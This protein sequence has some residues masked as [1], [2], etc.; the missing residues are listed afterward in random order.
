MSPNWASGEILRLLDEARA[1]RQLLVARFVLNHCPA[2]ATI[3]RDTADALADHEPPMLA[4]R[5]GQRV[6]FADAAQY[7]RL[8]FEL[9]ATSLAAREIAAVTREVAKLAS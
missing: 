8:V 7:G 1:F 9:D 3:A 5:I 4:A 2:R 6:A